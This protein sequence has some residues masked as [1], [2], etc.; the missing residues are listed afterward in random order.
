MPQTGSLQHT[1]WAEFSGWCLPLWLWFPS[2]PL[3]APAP[4]A[5]WKLSRERDE[6]Q[7]TEPSGFSKGVLRPQHHKFFLKRTHLFT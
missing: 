5:L 3:S 6:D 4:L 1:Y 2:P 7:G